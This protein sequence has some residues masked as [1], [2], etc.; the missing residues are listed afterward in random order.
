MT[1]AAIVFGQVANGFGCRT[2]R[3]SLFKIGLFTNR[4]LVVGEL[5]GVGIM[6]AISYVPFIADIFKTGPLTLARLGASSSSRPSSCSSPRRRENGSCGAG[7]RAAAPIAVTPT[8][9][10]GSLM[11]VIIVGC[12][13]VGAHTAAALAREGHDVVVIDKDPHA[14]RLLPQRLH[15]AHARGLRLRALRARGGRHRRGGRP[16]GG[17][18]RRQ[19]QRRDGARRQGGLPRART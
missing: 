14:F 16:R 6:L 4:F 3:E 18:R 2:E 13:R 7:R 12:G 10:E 5:I 9:K 8:G 11:K 17:D 15:G 19:H 1:Q